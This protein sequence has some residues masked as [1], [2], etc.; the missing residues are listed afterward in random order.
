MSRLDSDP[1]V[2]GRDVNDMQIYSQ[3]PN[4][5]IT[6]KVMGEGDAPEY[7]F[8]NPNNGEISLMQSV[9]YSGRNLYTVSIL[10][11]ETC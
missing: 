5:V 2:N 6:Y 10:L 1:L 8:C 4:N 7:F 9:R 3:A 11:T